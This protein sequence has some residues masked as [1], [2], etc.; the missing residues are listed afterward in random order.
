MAM[1]WISILLYAEIREDLKLEEHLALDHKPALVW[2]GNAEKLEQ[3]YEDLM[4]KYPVPERYS[5]YSSTR[6]GSQA[7]GEG[8]SIES[9]NINS[10][11]PLLKFP[12]SVSWFNGIN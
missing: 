12:K 10:K 11:P 8:V 5:A 2:N 1:G 7:A 6:A 9:E 3:D 4:D